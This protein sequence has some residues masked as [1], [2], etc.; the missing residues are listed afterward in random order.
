MSSIATN[1]TPPPVEPLQPSVVSLSDEDTKEEDEEEDRQS[2]AEPIMYTQ[3]TVANSQE[4]DGRSA[5]K[6]KLIPELRPESYTIVD[7]LEIETLI[8]ALTNREPGA[9]SN[10]VIILQRNPSLAS[11][12]YQI[13]SLDGTRQ[14]VYPLFHF[15]QVGSLASAVTVYSLY[16][17]AILATLNSTVGNQKRNAEESIHCF[18]PHHF[19]A[20]YGND[21]VLRF[22]V[23]QHP[24]ALAHNRPKSVFFMLCGRVQSIEMLKFCLKLYPKGLYEKDEKGHTLLHKACRQDCLDVRDN[25]IGHITTSLNFND[26]YLG[27][28]P[29]LI[30]FLVEKYPKLCEIS[31]NDGN[32][33][34]HLLLEQPRVPSSLFV[35]EN[36]EVN[37]FAITTNIF[38]STGLISPI[39]TASALLLINNY[40][41]ALE[42]TNSAGFL[43][44]DLAIEAGAS[45]DLLVAMGGKTKEE[46]APDDNLIQETVLKAHLS[47][48]Q[49]ATA[50]QHLVQLKVWDFGICAALASAVASILEAKS[51]V[52]QLTIAYTRL[53]SSGM[54]RLIKA[55][56]HNTNIL[57]CILASNIGYYA[58]QVVG[59]PLRLSEKEEEEELSSALH[60][61]L[62][63]N[64]TMTLLDLSDNVLPFSDPSWLKPLILDNKTLLGLNLSRTTTTTNNLSNDLILDILRHNSTLQELI[65]PCLQDDEDSAL[66]I[67]DILKLENKT[68]QRIVF[69]SSVPTVK[70][71]EAA[72]ETLKKNACL[73][74]IHFGGWQ[75]VQEKSS[76]SSGVDVKVSEL[77]GLWKKVDHEAKVNRAGRQKLRDKTHNKD[78]FVKSLP[79]DLST[80]YSLL[81]EAPQLWSAES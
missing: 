1:T 58:E 26:T 12:K 32:L 80:I 25:T 45:N 53:E 11:C 44:L 21:D 69:V 59:L 36:N 73:V 76:T 6:R 75:I 40:A 74:D 10:L 56:H 66:K 24:E 52:T 60:E 4:V 71:L 57:Q 29:E 62:I 81:R 3:A 7:E 19:A 22:L 18:T 42:M 41:K 65:L 30:Q 33:P 34:L 8:V 37:E 67:L 39:P 13:I 51:N 43:P 68:L 9:E 20:A 31:N 77:L 50:S 15:A 2:E 55:L 27:A 16:P 5:K 49:S 28:R 17:R 70:T 78:S 14:L 38:H 23:F 72:H 64:K 63:S 35:G 54:I 47:S 61:L 79:N 46:S 48:Q